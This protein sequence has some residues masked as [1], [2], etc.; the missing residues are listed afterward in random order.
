MTSESSFTH[1]NRCQNKTWH[2]ESKPFEKRGELQEDD[3]LTILFCDTSI[4]LECQV[5]QRTKLQV[6][7][8]NSE[9]GSSLNFFPPESTHRAPLWLK[10]M[11][12]EYKG[13]ALQI[14]PALDVGS[15][16]LALMGVRALLEIYISN[17]TAVPH[18]FK[19]KLADLQEREWISSQHVE[20]LLITFDAGSAAA[21][22][23]FIPTEA[24]VIIALQVI[25]NLIHRDILS[26][27]T[28]DLKNETPPRQL[29]K[30]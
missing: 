22:R 12:N 7:N 3:G 13:L 10:D 29:L 5:C 19:K 27:K 17:H 9:N 6:R 21:H 11:P 16:G 20:M 8:W 4:M 18:E 14:Y 25:E 30:K 23:G 28:K 24:S 1:C 26:A 2:S 15:Y